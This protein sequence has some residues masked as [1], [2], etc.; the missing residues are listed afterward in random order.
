VALLT[1]PAELALI[2]RMTRLPEVV[3]AAAV[4]LAPHHL[5]Y[6]A[7]DLAAAFHSFYRDCR[8][9]SAEPGDE[10]ITRARLKLAAACRVVLARALSLMGM[11]APEVM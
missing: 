2:R 10:A 6:F 3:M 4:Q 7:Y 11:S 8:V 9:I 1:N 5:A